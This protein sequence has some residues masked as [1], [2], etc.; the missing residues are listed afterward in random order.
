V[1]FWPRDEIARAHEAWPQVVQHADQDT[2]LACLNGIVE[3]GG[4]ID[5]PPARNAPC[6]CGSAVKHKKCCGRPGRG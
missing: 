4:A 5:W 6:W 3:Q 1:L 2:R